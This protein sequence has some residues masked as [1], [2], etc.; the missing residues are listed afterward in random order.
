MALRGSSSVAAA[1]NKQTNKAIMHQL[2][3][4]QRRDSC[5]ASECIALPSNTSGM[6][7]V[8]RLQ[9]G[10]RQQGQA[11]ATVGQSTAGR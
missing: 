7:R 2:Q 4:Q 8:M 10:A 9:P 6:G 5:G 11:I 3:Q 1:T